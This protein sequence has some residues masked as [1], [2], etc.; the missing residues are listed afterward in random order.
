MA[1]E[2]ISQYLDWK[3]EKKLIQWRNESKWMDQ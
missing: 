1:E 3:T 2:N